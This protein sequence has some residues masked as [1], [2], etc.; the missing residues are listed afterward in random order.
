MNVWTHM[1]KKIKLHILT[2]MHW[3]LK[4][5]F[6]KSKVNPGLF[7]PKLKFR[8]SSS[9]YSNLINRG[10][11]WCADFADVLQKVGGSAS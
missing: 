10:Q 6:Y 11:V 8:D 5:G 2:H 7:H 4:E 1:K 3:K 9:I